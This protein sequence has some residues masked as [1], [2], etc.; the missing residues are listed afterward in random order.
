MPWAVYAV[1]H[2]LVDCLAA[3]VFRNLWSCVVGP[4]SF[5]VDVFFKDIAKDV[6]VDFVCFASYGVIEVPG[7]GRKKLE[8]VF[9]SNVRDFNILIFNFYP[10]P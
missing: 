3:K 7:I 9:K 5:L 2:Q 4:K 8:Q 6:W 10:V 1:Q